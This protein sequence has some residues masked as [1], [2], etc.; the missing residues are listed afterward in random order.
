MSLA[1]FLCTLGRMNFR[2]VTS[3]FMSGF[4]GWAFTSAIITLA[5]YSVNVVLVLTSSRFLGDLVM[6][7]L[8]VH[9][10]GIP[11]INLIALIV[12]LW[13]GYVVFSRYKSKLDVKTAVDESTKT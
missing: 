3:V 7:H 4:A 5:I 10:F 6:L 2:Q 1:D 9:S 8:R 13:I 12:G 11:V